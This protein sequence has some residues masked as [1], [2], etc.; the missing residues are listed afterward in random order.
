ML[1]RKMVEQNCQR[2][3]VT[4]VRLSAPAEG[5]NPELSTPYD[6]VLVDAPCSNTGV[7]RRRVDLRWRIQPSEI[8]RLAKVQLDLLNVAAREVK[9]GGI[10]V[11]STCSLELEE[12][13]AVVEAFCKMLPDFILEQQRSLLPFEHSVDG[14]FVARLRRNPL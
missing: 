2:L 12:N 13:E 8:T 14:T 1:R 7:M 5:V 4:N 11:Y 3:G 9:P 10:L 6:R